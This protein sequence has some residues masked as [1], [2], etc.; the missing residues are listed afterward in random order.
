[1]SDKWEIVFHRPVGILPTE[2]ETVV[3]SEVFNVPQGAAYNYI[4]GNVLSGVCCMMEN[5]P[6]DSALSFAQ[7]GN[8]QLR[9][10]ESHGVVSRAHRFE[11]RPMRLL[12]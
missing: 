11:A 5:M 1:M 2:C 3:L 6:K 8:D 12:H 10:H 4:Q 9:A 7:H